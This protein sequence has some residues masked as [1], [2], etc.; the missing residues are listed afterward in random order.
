M[1]VSKHT[2]EIAHHALRRD[3]HKAKGL[4][5]PPAGMQSQ[6]GSRTDRGAIPAPTRKRERKRRK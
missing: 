6:E 2:R 5:Q 3:Q 4:W 1:K